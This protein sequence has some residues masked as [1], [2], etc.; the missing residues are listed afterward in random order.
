VKRIATIFA[1]AVMLA[2]AVVCR[3]D[4]P[5]RDVPWKAL[6]EIARR[7]D[8]VEHVAGFQGPDD[9]I[10]DLMQPP[11]DDSDKWF[12]TLVTTKGCAA[13]DRLKADFANSPE[14]KAWVDTVD[15]QRSWAH[16]QAVDVNDNT[17]QW[18]WANFKPRVFPTLIVQPPYNGSW[19][20]PHTVVFL[21]EG[22]DGK[23]AAL[24]K[25]IRAAL[26]MYGRKVH[27]QHVSFSR[28]LSPA[29]ISGGGFEQEQVIGE[30]P[31][32]FAPPSPQ[33]LQPFPTYQPFPQQ[34]PP[35][36]VQPQPPAQPSQ[37]LLYLLTFLTGTNLFATLLAPLLAGLKAR[38]AATPGKVDDLLVAALT[39]IVES[40]VSTLNKPAQS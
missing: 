1:A 20:D 8:S 36:D 38:A 25:A 28:K 17:Q 26:S 19:G 4:D 12:F 16:W 21:R 11:A 32:P 35:V 18:R 34:V 22:Y 33:P 31:A 13:C 14:L 10:A 5:E 23:P 9:P 24:D 15:Y 7:G 27:P 30:W 40:K 2:A 37:W 39:R 29:G 6:Q 3:A